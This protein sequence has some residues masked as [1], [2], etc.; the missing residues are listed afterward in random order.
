MSEPL[1]TAEEHAETIR[2]FIREQ[3]EPSD[4]AFDALNRL[5]QEIARL[6]RALEGAKDW[7]IR[8]DAS[9]L[10]QWCS[11]ALN[12]TGALTVFQPP[13][14]SATGDRLCFCVCCCR[15][16]TGYRADDERAECTCKVRAEDL[17]PRDAEI[18]RLR[19]LMARAASIAQN[20]QPDTTAGVVV[21]LLTAGGPE[22]EKDVDVIRTLADALWETGDE[23]HEVGWHTNSCIM[24]GAGVGKPCTKMCA[25]R[26]AALRLAGR[27]P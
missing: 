11:E 25:A 5:E 6:R 22:V 7:A 14:T 18:A 13:T 3:D 21:S 26:R 4:F 23:Y 2:D 8:S 27:V 20:L 12:P 16:Q 10:A 1:T 19:A 17:D 24:E 15:T 9:G